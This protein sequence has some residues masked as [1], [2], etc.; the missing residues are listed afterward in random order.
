MVRR[1]A[2]RSLGLSLIFIFGSLPFYSWGIDTKPW[3]GNLYEFEWH[4]SAVYQSFSSVASDSHFEK[5]SS[6]DFFLNRSLSNSCE[7]F[8]V[9]VEVTGARTR[10]QLWDIDHFSVTGRYVWTNDIAGDPLSFTTGVNLSKC[11]HRS[12]HDLSSFHHGLGEAE[13][14]VSIGAETEKDDIQW[15]KRGWG[16]FGIGIA[17][18]GS[19]WLRGQLAYEFRLCTYHEIGFQ[20]NTLWGLGS[21]RLRP[22]DFHGYGPIQHQSLDLGLRYTYLIEFVGNIGLEYYYRPYARNFPAQAHRVILSMLYTFGL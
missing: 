21:K 19:P 22:H 4:S 20:L 7:S 12:L 16:V 8:G 10:K 17:E 9:E 3:L 2:S 1:G 6:D 13:F 15:L 11:F 18:R 5:Y 14:F